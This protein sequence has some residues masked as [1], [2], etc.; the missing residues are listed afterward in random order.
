MIAVL[1]AVT[2]T[3]G[4]VMALRQTQAVRLLAWSSVAQSGYMLAPLAVG[5]HHLGQAVAA[6][7]AYVA[8]YA[9]M[10][11]GAFAV[12]TA[13]AAKS[14]PGPAESNPAESNLVEDYRGLARISPWHGVALAFFL[15]CLAGLPPGIMGLVAKITVFEGVVTGGVT[16]LA[17]V[18]AVNTVIGLYYYLAWAVRLFMPATGPY[19]MPASLPSLSAVTAT[20][21]G[22]VLLSVAPQLL[23][24]AA[25]SLG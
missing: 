16:W 6:T 21:V 5:S 25:L 13:F 4:N 23:L 11:L 3:A 9:I 20:A 22:A 8:F 14:S 7:T 15:V 19:E 24:Q 10:N 2:M 18:M 12:V 1:A 17:V